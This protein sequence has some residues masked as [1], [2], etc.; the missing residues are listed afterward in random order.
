MARLNF[1]LDPPES[2]AAAIAE[3]RRR[4][5]HALFWTVA[6]VA[7]LWLVLLVQWAA[8]IDPGHFGVRPHLP[9][10]LLGVLTAP[11]F[12]SGFPHLMANTSALL[13][14][15]TLAL[16]LYPR[17]LRWALPIIWIGSGLLVWWVARP[18]S[19]IGA[20]GIAHGLMFFIFAMGLLRRDRLA[21]MASMLVFFFYGG[22]VY[23]VLPQTPD[24]SFEYHL[25]G[26]LLGLLS[27]IALH[28]L[29]P[30]PPRKKYSWDYEEEDEDEDGELDWP[31][32]EPRSA[33]IS[34]PHE[35]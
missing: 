30:L 5:R 8:H 34:S 25:F 4:W 3:D 23:G 15:G 9:S 2:S 16:R 20:S 19:H 28:R 26:S 6:A 12:H 14:L 31:R 1:D 13:A 27:A 33:A 11:L 32:S 7:L 29:D 22:M 35:R 21:I 10:G 18:A 17:A 24:V